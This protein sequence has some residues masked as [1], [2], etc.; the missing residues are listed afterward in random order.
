MMHTCTELYMVIVGL[1]RYNN[2]FCL[3]RRPGFGQ[4]R[5]SIRRLR[6][7]RSPLLPNTAHGSHGPS[8]W[9]LEVVGLRR[10]GTPTGTVNASSIT[11]NHNS[12][13]RT[14]IW[15]IVLDLY[16]SLLKVRTWPLRNDTVPTFFLTG[17]VNDLLHWLPGLDLFF[18]PHLSGGERHQWTLYYLCRRFMVGRGKSSTLHHRP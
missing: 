16:L 9:N 3:D 13:A 7:T 2:H 18:L 17:T 12:S 11:W 5:P 14:I 1:C 6:L 15:R 4:S 10:L 8:W